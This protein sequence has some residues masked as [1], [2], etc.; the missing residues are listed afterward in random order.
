MLIVKAYICGELKIVSIKM[1]HWKK[2]IEF[3][4]HP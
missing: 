3:W 2:T 1:T 4:M